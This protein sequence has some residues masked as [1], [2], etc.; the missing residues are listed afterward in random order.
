MDFHD[1]AVSISSPRLLL[2]MFPAAPS[3]W[4]ALPRVQTCRTTHIVVTSCW[5]CAQLVVACRTRT[6]PRFILLKLGVSF[7]RLSTLFQDSKTDVN[8][9]KGS[10]I[11]ELKQ[12]KPMNMGTI[13]QCSNL[14]FRN[15]GGATTA[16]SLHVKLSVL[17]PILQAPQVA[18]RM[19]CEFTS[20]IPKN[21]VLTLT[22]PIS[23]SPYVPS[24]CAQSL[25]GA[26]A[27]SAH[28]SKHEE[29]QIFLFG[30]LIGSLCWIRILH[31]L[32]RRNQQ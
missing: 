9:H 24:R 31:P 5:L 26:L 8:C 19:F 18:H 12:R 7:I 4:W 1:A 23:Y 10:Q 21:T 27:R 32:A 20:R 17:E 14:I 6:C 30:R 11:I 29:Q 16:A 15:C 28:A 25:W 22:I 2:W 3:N 13:V